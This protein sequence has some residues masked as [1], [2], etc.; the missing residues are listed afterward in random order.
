MDGCCA[1]AHRLT[2]VPWTTLRVALSHL[3][4][5][6]APDHTAHRPD[7]DYLLIMI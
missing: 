2:T 7:D 3:D 6:F 1:S 4:S 5:R